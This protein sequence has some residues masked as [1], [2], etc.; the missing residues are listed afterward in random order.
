MKK[1]IIATVIMGLGF[2][3]MWKTVGYEAV[4]CGALASILYALYEIIEK[5]DKHEQHQ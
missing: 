3:I 4:I 5:I 2:Y 1:Q